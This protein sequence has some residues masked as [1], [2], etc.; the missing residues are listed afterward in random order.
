MAIEVNGTLAG[1]YDQIVLSGAATLGGILALSI[2]TT[3]EEG[4]EI[5]IISATAINGTFGSVTGISGKWKVVYGISDVKLVYDATALPVNLTAFAARVAGSHVQMAWT[6]ATEI[7]NAGFRIERS[8]DGVNWNNIGYVE[9]KGTVAQ[10][11]HY[12]FVDEE[13]FRGMNY[14]RLIQVDFDGKT[15][16]SRMRVVNFDS[17]SDLT[18]WADAASQ[19]YIK[20][21][22]SVEQV[23]IFDTSGRLKMT[24]K[25]IILEL[26]GTA[27][28]ILLFRIRTDK[29]VYSRKVVLGW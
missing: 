5:T 3:A 21:S 25:S 26:S 7:E 9:G 27:E 22:E 28:S 10:K 14:Y 16:V 20:T 29:G 4:D 1:E 24:S 11:Q 19:V 23:K 15:E 6:T 13:L 8:A 12:V 18:V 2:S 17:D